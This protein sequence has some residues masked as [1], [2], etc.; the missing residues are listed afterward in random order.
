METIIALGYTTLF[1]VGIALFMK[2]VKK[3]A[4]EQERQKPSYQRHN[5]AIIYGEAS[6]AR[7]DDFGTYN[8]LTRGRLYAYIESLSRYVRLGYLSAGQGSQ[9]TVALY[10]DWEKVDENTIKGMVEYFADDGSLSPGPLGSLRVWGGPVECELKIG[11]V[12]P[13]GYKIG[14]A[15]SLGKIVDNIAHG[16]HLTF[17]ITHFYIPS[18]N[19]PID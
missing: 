12:F 15:G 2:W 16:K 1:F 14:R 9:I 7:T 6:G 4:K 5:G 18:S 8:R 19:S 3:K 17:K 11:E 13:L 10:G